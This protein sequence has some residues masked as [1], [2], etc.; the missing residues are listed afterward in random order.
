[1]S[2]SFFT[3][4]FHPIYSIFELY[5]QFSSLFF[6]TFFNYPHYNIKKRNVKEKNHD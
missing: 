2:F 4:L 1:M 5:V 3:R 6:P